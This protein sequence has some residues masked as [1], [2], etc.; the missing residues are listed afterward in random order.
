VVHE[1][2]AFHSLITPGPA[3]TLQPTAPEY[4]LKLKRPQAIAEVRL[5]HS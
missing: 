4:W 3:P 5:S 1:L 2:L